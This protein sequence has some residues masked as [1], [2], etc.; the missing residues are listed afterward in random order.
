[1]SLAE[2][3]RG[4]RLPYTV[5]PLRVADTTE[6][7]QA[8]VEA[9]RRLRAATLKGRGV[10]EA[11]AAVEEAQ[12]ALDGCFEQLT[13]HAVTAHRYEEIVAEHP[14]RPGNKDD[15]QLGYDY[16]AVRLALLVEGAEGDATAEDWQEFFANCSA[17]EKA[18][19]LLVVQ[20]L[21]ARG[22]AATIPKGSTPT[23]A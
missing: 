4:R 2:R 20:A 11:Q 22:P 1:M 13:I 17:G 14:P 19:L 21:N 9:R 12:A 16:E 3:L 7:E 6:A 23:P 10:E 15:N 18:E 8:L 5:Y